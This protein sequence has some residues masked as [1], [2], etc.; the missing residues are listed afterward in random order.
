MYAE[1]RFR[2]PQ[3]DTNE[4][5][6]T[7]QV[8]LAVCMLNAK[9]W[10]ALILPTHEGRPLWV[11]GYQ[12]GL[13]YEGAWFNTQTARTR[14]E[15][16]ER[17]PIPVLTGSDVDQRATSTPN[18]N[19]HRSKQLPLQHCLSKAVSLFSTISYNVQRTGN[20][21]SVLKVTAMTSNWFSTCILF[22]LWRPWVVFSALASVTEVN[23]RRKNK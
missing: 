3:L 19:K 9:L 16:R 23:L 14:L 4:I 8:H 5:M 10:P 21:R 2:S 13:T 12:A 1:P 18:R 6:D 11:Y 17:S 15:F 22:Q 7:E 20:V